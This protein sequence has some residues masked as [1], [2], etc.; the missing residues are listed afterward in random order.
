MSE[1]DMVMVVLVVRGRGW[2]PLGVRVRVRRLKARG[3]IR[4]EVRAR[5]SGTDS[6]LDEGLKMLTSGWPIWQHGQ[7]DR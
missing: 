1:A 7:I 4:K 6:D 5:L 2:W 3:E